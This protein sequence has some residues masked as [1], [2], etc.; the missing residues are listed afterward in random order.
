MNQQP[1]AN[2]QLYGILSRK[3]FIPEI[4]PGQ[5]SLLFFSDPENIKRYLHATI[6]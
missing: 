5:E 6:C 4:E 1:N 2:F 3:E